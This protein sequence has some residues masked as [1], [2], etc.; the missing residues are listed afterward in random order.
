MYRLL[1]AL[2]QQIG[3][4]T[5]LQAIVLAHEERWFED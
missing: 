3:V 4:S 1:Q 2:Y 5:R